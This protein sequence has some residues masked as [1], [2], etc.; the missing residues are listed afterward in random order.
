MFTSVNQVTD[1]WE[2]TEEIHRKM[3]KRKLHRDPPLG[4]F[5]LKKIK[6]CLDETQKSRLVKKVMLHPPHELLPSL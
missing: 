4:F 1:S 6:K 3:I 5:R 2:F